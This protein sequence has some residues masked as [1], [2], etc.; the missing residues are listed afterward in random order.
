MRIFLILQAEGG[1]WTK[2]QGVRTA[3]PS[4][5]PHPGAIV[6]GGSSGHE[7]H[8][9]EISEPLLPEAAT[10]TCS[11]HSSKFWPPDENERRFRAELG[12]STRARV[13]AAKPKG[14]RSEE[15]SEP[16]LPEAAATPC[17]TREKV[18]EPLLPEAAATTGSSRKH[19]TQLEPAWL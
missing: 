10:T 16:L 2:R 8:T 6:T 1:M 4:H 18:S 11:S 13:Q 19:Q 14:C 7:I 15:A 9:R 12:R 5:G 17:S 3:H